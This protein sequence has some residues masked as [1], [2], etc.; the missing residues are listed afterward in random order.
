MS[1]REVVRSRP[2]FDMADGAVLVGAA[3]IEAG[4]ALVSTGVALVVG[5]LAVVGVVALWKR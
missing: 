3:L 5:G 4:L 2:P 1:R